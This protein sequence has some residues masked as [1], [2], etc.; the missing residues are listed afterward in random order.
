[1]KKRTVLFLGLC[2]LMLVGCGK[3][4]DA[5]STYLNKYIEDSVMK[6][7]N[8]ESDEWYQKYEEISND[9]VI[10]ADGF[11][12]S[13][14]VDYSVLEDSDAVH[15]TFA[16][17]S[18]ITVA[19]FDDPAKS[20]LIDLGGAYMHGDDCIYAE[21]IEINNPNTDAYQFSG[22]EVWEFDENGKKKRELETESSEDG[23]VYQIP[24]EFRG[25]EISIIPLG[26]YVPRNIELKDYFK[27][28]NGVERSLAGTWDINGEK[29]TN[30]STSVSPVA[31]YTDN[32]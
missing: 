17:N 23:L 9:E 30:S 26:E 22:F 20:S 8:I 29:T 10:N 12:S 18:Y 5:I 32:M 27:D 25:R 2:M 31:S 7:S 28:N 14:D 11:Y 21:I 19:Y 3:K 1:M 6:A 24:M 4:D 16:Q 15:V 13:D